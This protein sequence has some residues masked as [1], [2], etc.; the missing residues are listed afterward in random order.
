SLQQGAD[1][2]GEAPAPP[3]QA[4]GN[5]EGNWQ[6]SADFSR[7]RSPTQ[8]SQSA[9]A[10]NRNRHRKLWPIVG[11]V[12]ISVLAA[13]IGLNWWQNRPKVTLPN[14]PEIP[15]QSLGQNQQNIDLQT[16]STRI[17]TATATE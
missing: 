11:I 10:R 2:W 8:A 6:N 4:T 1:L 14:I 5:F 16:A 7:R 15:T 12:G 9:P 17:V 3:S 13:T